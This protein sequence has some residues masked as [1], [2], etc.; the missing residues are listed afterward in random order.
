MKKTILSLLT[1]A[2]LCSTLVACG[3][4]GTTTTPDAGT[5][6]GGTSTPAPSGG[7]DSGEAVTLRVF[8]H[9]ADRK[10][11]QGLVEQML[12]DEYM[13]LN[14]HVTIQVEALDEQA[15][16]TKFRAYSAD[17]MP[18]L[19]NV[20]GHPS[21]L[22][23]VVSA[24]V[25]AELDPADYADYTFIEGSTIGFQQDGKLYGLPRNT[26][27]VGFYYNQ[28]IFEDN[29]WSV[30]GTYDDLLALAGEMKAANI[31]PVAMDG[32][33]GW[34]LAVYYSDILNKVIGTEFSTVANE[35]V[36]NKDFSHPA[37]A[38]ATQILVDSVSAGLFQNGF[39]T[40]DYATAMNLFTNGQAAMYYMGSWESSMA[41]NQD[42]DPEIRDNIRVFLMPD[43][44]GASGTTDITA[45]N[46]GGY[47][48][49][50]HSEQKEE[51]LKLLNFMYE[52]DKL[53]KYGWENGVGMSAQD[54]T[55]FLTG[56]ESE[57]LMQFVDVV[58]SS[59]S[60]S[61]P[62]LND[63]GSA[64]FKSVIESE[65]QSVSTGAISVEDFLSALEAGA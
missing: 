19:V 46:G 50:A 6:T 20:W 29:G 3:G 59:T 55:D 17:G 8:T 62:T 7:G 53:S 40:Q 56:D 52:P 1:T 35:A 30:P 9:L 21:F 13:E 5:G 39:D 27:V 37:F 2:L 44:G 10:N 28:K 48:V 61:G 11:G 41:V 23:E 54:Q 36:A 58:N 57:L 14:P 63:C 12:I 49:Y 16:K 42:I 22:S 64:S 18:D 38:E 31:I 51:A 24:G 15:Y 4:T 65:I 33:D 25:L 47:S 34:P 26:D 60:V 32:G 43:V 45:W